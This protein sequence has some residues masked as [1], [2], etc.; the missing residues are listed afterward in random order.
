M[1]T[2]QIVL[3]QDVQT[4]LHLRLPLRDLELLRS[5]RA[6]HHPPADSAVA[7]IFG[8]STRSRRCD[9]EVDPNKFW[10]FSEKL[11]DA[12]YDYLMSTW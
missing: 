9:S 12:R 1:L 3:G 11:S 2:R 7:P 5:E 4:P 8:I 6:V 10:D